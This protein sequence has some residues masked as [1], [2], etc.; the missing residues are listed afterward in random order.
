MLGGAGGF[1]GTGENLI[2]S[3]EEDGA[4]LVLGAERECGGCDGTRQQGVVGA[5]LTEDDKLGSRERLRAGLGVAVDVGGEG[6]E[7][8]DGQL[9]AVRGVVLDAAKLAPRLE[10]DAAQ[11]IAEGLAVELAGVAVG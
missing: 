10:H 9:V 4:V 1:V 3:G 5:A 7:G 2:P 8:R 11:L 6:L